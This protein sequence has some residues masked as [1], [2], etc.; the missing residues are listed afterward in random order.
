MRDAIEE[1]ACWGPAGG[2][3]VLPRRVDAELPEVVVFLRQEA[4]V[5][6]AEFAAGFPGNGRVDSSGGVGGVGGVSGGFGVEV[7]AAGC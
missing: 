6:A 4:V 7:P 2:E 5:D 3:V 1:A